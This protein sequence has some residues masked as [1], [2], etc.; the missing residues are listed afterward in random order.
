MTADDYSGNFHRLTKKDLQAQIENLQTRLEE[1]EA[2]L[3]AIR[4]GEVDAVVV[5][6]PNGKMVY[7]L[8]GADYLY[9][10]LVQ[11]MHDAAIIVS[12]DGTILFCNQYFTEIVRTSQSTVIGSSLFT[13]VVPEDQEKLKAWIRSLDGAG[14]KGEIRFRSG[15]SSSI[16][17]SISL[18]R[19]SEAKGICVVATD[20]STQKQIEDK[21]RGEYNAVQEAL[22]NSQ[23]KYQALVETT[24]D[25]IWETDAQGRYTYCSPQM[26]SLWG[27]PPESMIGKTLFDRM[28]DGER[29]QGMTFF[30]QLVRSPNPFRNLETIEYDE[31]G[32]QIF[33]E[34]SGVPFFDEAGRLLGY[35][36]VTRDVTNRKRAEEA[37]HESE[38]RLKSV[39]ESMSDILV[40]WNI[41]TKRYEYISP[42]VKALVGY[43]PDEFLGMDEESAL[44][45]VHPDDTAVLRAAQARSEKTGQASAEY[46]QRTMGGDYIWVSNRMTVVKDI[47]GQPLY[48]TSS[49][50]DVTWQKKAEESLAADFAALTR[51][52]E[53]STR[54][55]DN[56]GLQPILQEIM[57]AAVSIMGAD[58]GTLQLLEGNTL[59]IVAAHSHQQPF[60]DFFASA[61]QQVSACGMAMKCT[62]RVVVPDIET[63]PLFAG[64][65][66]LIVLKEA[67]VR[68]VQSTPLVSRSGILMGVLTTHWGAPHN[69]SEHDLWRLDLLARQAADLIEYSQGEAKVRESETI[70]QSY[71]D[72]SDVMRGIVDLIADDEIR[73]IKVNKATA[74]FMGLT[75]NQVENK[76]ATEIGDIRKLRTQWIPYYLQSKETGKPV[77]FN[78][79]DNRGE[80]RWLSITVNYLGIF[81]EGFPRFTLVIH[82]I[83]E[84]KNAEEIIRE[85]EA[86]KIASTVVEH[87]RQRL[88]S[89]LETMPI[90]ISL[91]TPDYHV[92]FANRSFRPDRTL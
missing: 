12:E 64:T 82:D 23:K 88:F 1:S 54:L 71:F 72:A 2:T 69:P 30:M 52:H 62:S 22:R 89:V 81:P 21:L 13:H 20:L 40:R 74:A 28:P 51:M 91:L 76:T 17:T 26:K 55:M 58:K 47:D 37:L 92:A 83:T 9:R 19:T 44:A 45:M 7:T 36:G 3:R 31:Q 38:A 73:F 70:L 61:E 59:R 79:L 27:I 68:S 34:T 65:N 50:R 60:L 41:Q 39:L 33:V 18:T 78:F 32:H 35:R 46:R 63:S 6:G 43:S 90:M 66:S 8:Q 75:P 85:N 29:E 56:R 67:G 53:I 49:I 16:P 86:R 84:R 87:E 48:R 15:R 80:D 10:M 77:T 4:K 25:F 5:D 24:G 14:K 11:D 57:D 42:S